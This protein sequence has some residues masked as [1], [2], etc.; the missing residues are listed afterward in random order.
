MHRVESRV[1]SRRRE[2]EREAKEWDKYIYICKSE[3]N[4]GR[5]SKIRG[6]RKGERRKE[7][8][9]RRRNRKIYRRFRGSERKSLSSTRTLGRAMKLASNSPCP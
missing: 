7:R 3:N 9:R 5:R 4:E 1:E 6:E 8:T 2:P